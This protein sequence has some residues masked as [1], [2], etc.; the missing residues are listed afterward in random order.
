MFLIHAVAKINLDFFFKLRELI[1]GKYCI[2]YG[3]GNYSV[4]LPHIFMLN[5]K[6]EKHLVSGELTVLS[7]QLQLRNLTGIHFNFSVLIGKRWCC[8]RR[9]LSNMS[10]SIHSQPFSSFCLA[11]NF[12]RPFCDC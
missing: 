11:H 3:G 2:L 7:D 8:E 12:Q 5:S 6:Q 1:M 4:I 9:H 10:H